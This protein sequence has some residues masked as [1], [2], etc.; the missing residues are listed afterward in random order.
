MWFALVTFTHMKSF[1]VH[2]IDDQTVKLI[3]Q[4]AKESGL[5]RNKTIQS[6][7]H[8]ALGITEIKEK[9]DFSTFLGR[10]TD[11]EYQNFNQSIA[12]LD[13]VDKEDWA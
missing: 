3:D 2:N 9:A 1:T 11:E 5:S 8:K 6:L 13:T 12:D 10:W 7:L 4:K